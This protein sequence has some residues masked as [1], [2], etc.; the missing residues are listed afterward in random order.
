MRE[1]TAD[2]ELLVH[3]FLNLHTRHIGST[4]PGVSREV[5][6]LL[7][8]YRWPGNVR[9]LSNLVEYLVNIVPDGEVIDPTLLPPHFHRA[10]TTTLPAVEAVT[11]TT[12]AVPPSLKQLE[13]QRIIEALGRGVSKAQLAQELEISVATLYRKIKKYGLRDIH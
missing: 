8:D 10:T 12:P 5:M 13:H 3:H 2:I 7:R 11:A 4:Y 6:A 9:E 1:R